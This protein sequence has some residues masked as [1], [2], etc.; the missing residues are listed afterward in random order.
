MS[1]NTEDLPDDAKKSMCSTS[2]KA[3][4]LVNRCI[5]DYTVAINFDEPVS[6]YVEDKVLA[7]DAKIT[8]NGIM[9]AQQEDLKKDIEGLGKVLQESADP[10][11]NG[12]CVS[13]SLYSIGNGAMTAEMVSSELIKKE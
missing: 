11:V 8:F 6:C 7:F 10:S 3:L 12:V 4:L 1:I 13:M 9:S 2:L 5:G